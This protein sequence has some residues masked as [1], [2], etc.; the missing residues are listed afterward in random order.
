MSDRVRK[1]RGKFIVFEGTDGC[2]KTTHVSLLCEHLSRK[3]GR[4]CL[5]E[6]EPDSRNIVGAI[7]RSALYGS[8]KILPES[9]AYLHIA[10]R[11]EHIGHILPLLDEGY[12]IVCDRYYISNMAYN[13]GDGL[14][15]GDIYRL[16]APCAA[17]LQPDLVVFLDVSPEETARRRSQ[18][19]TDAEIYDEDEKQKKIRANYAEALS[20][21]EA[22]G[23]RVLRVDASR[24]KEEVAAEIAAAADRL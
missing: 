13:A 2:G 3:T 9:M 12:D 7:I 20:I 5:S 23:V 15:V 10:D 16:N 1:K 17:K 21:V 11:L 4:K 22:A 19:R 14:S 24:P 6:R 18:D 8:V